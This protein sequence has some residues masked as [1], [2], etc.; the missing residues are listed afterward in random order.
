M[1]DYGHSF[2]EQ[3]WF[4][5][6]DPGCE[7]T[8]DPERAKEFYGELFDWKLEEVPDMNYTIIN[9]GEGTGGGIMKTVHT[10]LTIFACAYCWWDNL[11]RITG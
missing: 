3:E 9:V 7:H 10:F 1:V 4:G 2:P 5:R 11:V 6:S 8:Q